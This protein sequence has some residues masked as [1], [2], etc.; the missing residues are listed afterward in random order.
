M[1]AHQ[2][3]LAGC[4]H[5]LLPSI[6]C[7]VIRRT[8][9]PLVGAGLLTTYNFN[10]KLFPLVTGNETLVLAHQVIKSHLRMTE[11]TEAYGAGKP[12]MSVNVPMLE[13]VGGVTQ[14]P[15]RLLVIEVYAVNNPGQ[16]D[17]CPPDWTETG[18]AWVNCSWAIPVQHPTKARAIT[19]EVRLSLGSIF[20]V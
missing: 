14:N 1:A 16:S 20:M 13:L 11:V 3:L 19:M 6:H 2:G 9:G 7:Q 12:D 8:N 17:P 18:R 4:R 5:W 10:W 15:P